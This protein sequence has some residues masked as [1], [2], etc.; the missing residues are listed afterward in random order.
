MPPDSPPFTVL[1]PPR[2]VLAVPPVPRAHDLLD[3]HF[4]RALGLK[5]RRLQQQQA[6]PPPAAAAP[7]PRFVTTVTQGRFLP[8]PPPLAALLGLEHLYPPEPSPPAPNQVY[9]YS[10]RPQAVKTRTRR[11]APQQP[12]PPPQVPPQPRGGL[13]G[14]RALALGVVGLH[15][16]YVLY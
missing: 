8:P 1:P 9:S 7:R 12:P 11:A 5:L 10:S 16:L 6:P 4:S 2:R 14:L 15:R 3:P 13:A